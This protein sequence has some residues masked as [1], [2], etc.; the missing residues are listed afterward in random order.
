MIPS[1]FYISA[2]AYERGERFWSELMNEAFS[3]NTKASSD[4]S[5]VLTIDR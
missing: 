3:V 1:R 5:L 2:Q 4:L